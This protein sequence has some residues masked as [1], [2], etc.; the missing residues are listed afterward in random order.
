MAGS[1]FS[2]SGVCAASV[3][4]DPTSSFEYVA[5]NCNGLGVL[6]YTI[7]R[8][9]GALSTMA[10][11]PWPAGIGPFSIAVRQVIPDS[12]FFVPVF[13]DN[14]NGFVEVAIISL[15]QNSPGINFATQSMFLTYGSSSITIP[16]GSLRQLDSKDWM[17]LGSVN[18]VGVAVDVYQASATQYLVG[19][20]AGLNLTSQPQSLNVG[21]QIGPNAGSANVHH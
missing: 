17:F 6:G 8:T 20:A 18:G 3:A 1:P 9:T 19:V 15:G 12:G 10:G 7:N 4:V 13:N 21:V 5:D 2:A 14:R 11:S 16:P